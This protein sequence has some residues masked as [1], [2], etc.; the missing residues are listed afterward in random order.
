MTVEA[1][2]A[3][4]A[5]NIA[6][7]RDIVRATAGRLPDASLSPAS[8]AMQHGIMTARDRISPEAHTKLKPLVGRYLE[9]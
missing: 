3:V 4:M 6:G 5:K 9:S 8:S 7:A 2:M 1:V